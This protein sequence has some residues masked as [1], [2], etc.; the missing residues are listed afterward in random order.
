MRHTEEVPELGMDSLE[1]KRV[2]V[3]QRSDLLRRVALN[4]SVSDDGCERK[5]SLAEVER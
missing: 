4:D 5:R 1:E 2:K 3:T